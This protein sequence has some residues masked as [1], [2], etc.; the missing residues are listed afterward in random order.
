MVKS[1]KNPQTKLINFANG[2]CLAL[3]YLYCSERKVEDDKESTKLCIDAWQKGLLEDDG[4]VKSAYDLLKFYDGNSYDVFK[5]D[6][7]SISDIKE[8][9]PVRYYAKGFIPHWVVVENGKIV[10]NPIINSNS[11]NKGRPETAR[12]IKKRG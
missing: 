2:I 8:P 11:V 12:I 3:C 10:F 5:K 9:T 4:T 6:I 7:S 1:M